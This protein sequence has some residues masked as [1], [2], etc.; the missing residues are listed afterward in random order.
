MIEHRVVVIGGG[1]VGL[2]VAKGLSRPPFQVTLVDLRNF[3]LF[4]P[5]LYQVATGA[6]AGA[7]ITSP[8]RQIL[9]RQRNT[10][11]VMAEI[12]GFDPIA[13][14]VLCGDVIMPYDTLVV[15]A[16][17]RPHYFAHPEWAIHAPGLKTLE[18]AVLI[19]SRVFKAFEE[20]EKEVDPEQI[21]SHLTF[22]VV[23]GGPTGL[24]L[25]GALAEIARKTLVGEFRRIDPGSA[26]ILLV[27]ADDR[28]IGQLSSDSSR[29][30][31]N[32]LAA[33]G[34]ELALHTRVTAI[35]ADGVELLGADGPQRIATK[36]VLWAAGVGAS[37]LAVLLATAT[38][39][40][41]DRGGRIVVND[42]CQISGHPEIY[43]LGD[44][45]C[46]I[47]DGSPLP[48]IAQVA[49][50][51]GVHVALEIRARIQ[52]KPTVPF[53]YRSKGDMATIGKRR[54]VAEVGTWRLH[55]R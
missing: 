4:Q 16:G 22:I 17:S 1:F 36:T 11:V 5:L 53:T 18:D 45:A 46:F 41:R 13:R 50:Q 24:E 51:Q 14:T 47:Q 20:A 43:V 34:V 28:I 54:A 42:H 15:A 8:L 23:G 38:G 6:L 2:E 9:R 10:R 44:M 55:G 12:T 3:H 32:S 35:D 52:G 31:A 39:A 26:R 37:P 40:E 7:N 49:V 48:G 30:A 33:L 29:H 19:R 27:E 21:R 25:A